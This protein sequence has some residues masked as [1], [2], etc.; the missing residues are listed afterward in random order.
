MQKTCGHLNRMKTH[1][2]SEDT[3]DVCTSGLARD[4]DPSRHARDTDPSGHTRDA[5]FLWIHWRPV[6]WQIQEMMSCQNTLDMLARRNT[7]EIMDH[8]NILGN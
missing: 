5:S 3:L 4:A 2:T 6:P 7:H 8:W 1:C